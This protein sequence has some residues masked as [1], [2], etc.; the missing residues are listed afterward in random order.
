MDPVK[1]ASKG[2]KHMCGGG[3][4]L[5]GRAVHKHRLKFHVMSHILL[6]SLL[7]QV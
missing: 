4:G 2:R 1:G 3:K 7:E 6:K 5:K